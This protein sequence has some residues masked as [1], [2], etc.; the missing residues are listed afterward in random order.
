MVR[1]EVLGQIL[2]HISQ[3]HDQQGEMT[4]RFIPVNGNS[5]AVDVG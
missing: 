4:N 1:Q 2:K 5:S 3:K